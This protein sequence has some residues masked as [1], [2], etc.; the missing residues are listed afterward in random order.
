MANDSELE[1][2]ITARDELSP[3]LKSI[4]S[5]IIR[6]VGSITAAFASIKLA[7]AP[8]VA[9]THLERELANVAKTT[10]FSAA[11]MRTLQKELLNLSLQVDVTAVDLAKIAAAAGQQGLGSQGVAGV[12]AFTDTVSRMSSVLGISAEEAATNVGKILNI[13]KISLRDVEKASSIVNEVS[14]NTV[15]DGEHLLDVIKRIGTAAGSLNIQ[16]T[17]ALAA[18]GLGL[19][20]SAEVVGSAFTKIFTAFREKA[21][22]FADLTKGVVLSTGEK[23]GGGSKQWLKVVQDNGVEALKAYLEALRKLA[24]EKQALAI[25]K[26]TG[27]GRQGTLTQKLVQDSTNSVLNQAL[28]FA[29]E[30]AKGESSIKER[31]KV[32]Q[33]LDAQIKILKNSFTALGVEAALGGAES[34][35]SLVNTLTGYTAQLSSFL[36][37]AGVKLFIKVL[38]DS[39]VDLV[40]LIAKGTTFISSLNVNWTAFVQIAKAFLELRLAQSIG[41]FVGKLSGAGSLL[42]VF[43]NHTKEL[44]E[45]TKTASAATAGTAAAEAKTVASLKSKIL[46]FEELSIIWQKNK[47]D[48]DALRIAQEQLDKAKLAT[49]VPS[50]LNVLAQGHAKNSGEVAGVA[51]AEAAAASAALQKTQ[52]SIQARQLASNAI[53]NTRI[54]Q[55]EEK[56]N[57]VLLEIEKVYQ[58]EKQKIKDTGTTVGMTALKREYANQQAQAEEQFQRSLRGI[59][60]YYSRKEAI[61]AAGE[62]ATLAASQAGLLAAQGKVV[63]TGGLNKA[64][65]SVAA[66]TA[67]AATA[68]AGAVALASAKVTELEATT[69]KGAISLELLGAAFRGLV[70]FIGKAVSFIFIFVTGAQ[71]LF[72]VLDSLGIIDKL[73]NSLQ[74]LAS[75]LGLTTKATRDLAAAENERIEKAR[76]EMDVIQE[77]IELLKKLQTATGELST[78]KLKANLIKIQS[79]EDPAQKEKLRAETFNPLAELAREAD[80]KTA[81]AKKE[82]LRK[83][84]DDKIAAVKGAEAKIAEIAKASALQETLFGKSNEGAEKLKEQLK[85][86][87]T[88]LADFKQ[89]VE[90]QKAA[91]VAVDVNVAQSKENLAKAIPLI[92]AAFIEASFELFVKFV[93][94]ITAVQD[95]IKELEIQQRELQQ[96]AVGDPKAAEA[97]KQVVADLEVQKVK[98][99]QL[100]EEYKKAEAAKLSFATTP[101]QKAAILSVRDELSL[102]NKTAVAKRDLLL[103]S[104]PE[105]RTGVLAQ[106]PATPTTGTKDFSN[107]RDEARAK[108]AAQLALDKALLEARFKLAEENSH[109]LQIIEDED[110][111]QGLVSIKQYYADRERVQL[112][113][114]DRSIALKNAEI[115]AN[116]DSEKQ[117]AKDLKPSDKIK[118]QATRATLQGE[119][120]VLLAQRGEIVKKTEF[121]LAAEIKSFNETLNSETLN[122]IQEGFIRGGPQ[123]IADATFKDLELKNKEHIAKLRKEGKDGLAD[124]IE[125]KFK[126]TSFDN[127]ISSVEKKLQ[128]ANDEFSRA[129]DR[130]SIEQQKGTLTA[131][132]T[133]VAHDKAIRDSIESQKIFLQQEEVYLAQLR[134]Q[135]DL[136]PRLNQAYEERAGKVDQLRLN[137]EKLGQETD[138]TAKSINTSLVDSFANASDNILTKGSSLSDQLKAFFKSVADDVNK[139]F[140]KDIAENL[141]KSLGSTGSGGF[142]GAIQNVIQGKGFGDFFGGVAGKIGGLF[143]PATGPAPG[144]TGVGSVAQD[145]F[146]SSEISTGNTDQTAAVTASTDAFGQVTK[147]AVA[148]A[149][150]TGIVNAIMGFFGLSTST[151]TTIASAAVDG[152]GFACGAAIF[153]VEALSLAMDQ[154]ALKS[155]FGAAHGGGIIGSSPLS[156]RRVSPLVFM[157]APRYHSGGTAGLLPNEVPAILEKGEAVLTKRQQATVTAAMQGGGGPQKEMNIRNILVTDPNF[158]HDA[159]GSS[160]GEKTLISFVSKNRA[161]LK[162]M[163]G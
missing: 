77:Q 124:A 123:E 107:A 99:I 45:A 119:I 68:A 96:K 12:V 15:A 101:E 93:P 155:L 125:I 152:L 10:D 44:A 106:K 16:Q 48:A 22:K 21:E 55:A 79:T 4:E 102:P 148:Q 159:L 37:G 35:K 160:Q 23:L 89:K 114:N 64:D 145:A 78:E 108:F 122:A 135:A 139:M 32:V 36:Q 47:R 131:V 110:F 163:L 3:Q 140:S 109:R 70:S 71:I 88:E 158:V 66:G 143:G 130:L 67:A 63:A 144:A 85:A 121:E 58:A 154:V 84:L 14:N 83:E 43:T 27:A 72:S 18:T 92:A 13:F 50:N 56:K 94:D 42:G 76:E 97:L 128:L 61:V 59:E 51:Q 7:A 90:A 34:G 149:E 25:G 103:Q 1:V 75:M 151:T 87:T 142:G 95:K 137:I 60:S 52:E 57:L 30:G 156:S 146:R 73:P 28:G 127:V 46:G 5:S 134:A 150:Q 40:S 54:Q 17:T 39:F 117:F 136:D 69:T 82:D 116:L 26:L 86:A 98:L 8:I 19:G 157:G 49:V 126:V 129:Q 118:N 74:K 20:Q 105:Q 31:L 24:P 38:K 29:E 120:D 62:A 11:Q 162:Q 147:A 100:Q 80:A 153:A 138:R 9:A 81:Q 53:V 6:T 91:L 141:F 33:T 112:E 132:Q 41:N 161:T 65:T 104:T 2:R 133:E 115:K 113:S 111:K